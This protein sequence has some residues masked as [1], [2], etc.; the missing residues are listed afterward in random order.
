QENALN[1]L[2]AARDM[3]IFPSFSPDANAAFPMVATQDIGRLA[4]E[5]LLA[6]PAKHEVI[7]IQ[8]P[9]YSMRQVAE[10]LGAALGKKLNLVEIPEAGWVDGLMRGGF[11][12]HVAEV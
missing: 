4:A 12:K 11:P 7:D 3:G 8:G 6:R 5:Q 2:G 9:A 1:V 10:K